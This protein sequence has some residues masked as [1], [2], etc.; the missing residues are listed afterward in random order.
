MKITRVKLYVVNVPECRWWWSDDVYGQPAHQRADHKVVEV[1]TDQGLTG[2]TEVSYTAPLE[3]IQNALPA[4]IGQDILTINLADLKDIPFPGAFEQAVL[5]LRGQAL[6]VPVHQLLGGRLRDR[7]FITQCTGY[8]TPEHTA[9]DA[10]GG[11]ERGFRAYKMKCITAAEKTPE[12]RIRYVT[13]RVEA[14]HRVL[15]DMLVRPDIRWRLEEVWV[16]QEL[17]RRLDG[18]LLDSLESPI[19]RRTPASLPEWRRL[20]QT[21]RLPI[22]DHVNGQ[23]LIAAFQ[24]EA[25]DYAIV[26]AETAGETLHQSRLAHQLGLGGWSQ[27]VAYGPGAAMGLHVAAC[28]PHLTRPYDMVGPMVWQDTLVNEPFPIEEGGFSVPDRPGLGYTLNHEAV[29]KYLVG[30]QT[31][32]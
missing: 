16:A 10:K 29:A 4:W 21:I 28:M 13:E 24:A 5:D 20:R 17:A 3:T 26:G 6:G 32:E 8:K 9:E 7:V 19:R 23:D 18:H 15:P 11:W 25:L 30:Q 22:G 14:I 12:A 31:F 27:T 1:E 2:L